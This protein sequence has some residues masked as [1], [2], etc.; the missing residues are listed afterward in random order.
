MRSI[1]TQGLTH[2]YSSTETV[3]NGIDLQ[4]EEGRIYGFLG[5]NGAGKT[6]TLRLILGLLKKQAGE[7]NIFGKRLES[8][9]IE[10]LRE[11]GSLIE[12]PSI[13]GHLTAA[14]NLRVFQT[15]YQSPASRTNEVLELVGLGETGKKK[16]GH[17]SLGMKQRLSIATALLHKPRLL[18]LDEP[19]NG[20]D[21]EGI[22]EMRDLLKRL[23]QEDGIT[24]LISSHLLSEIEKLV[25]DVGI[26]HKGRILFQGTL[27]EL[28]NRQRASS[29]V[30]FRT[31]DNAK[32][33]AA[34]AERQVNIV[35][36]NGRIA[37]SGL[38]EEAVALLNKELV[39]SGVDVYAIERI[40]DD[41]ERIFLDVIKS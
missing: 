28:Q 41:L 19:T 23:K 37:T 1:E 2:R 16:A 17:F 35:S 24:I 22:L 13:Y 25:D 7:I 32:A 31:S 30:A 36:Q 33:A 5:P 11:I 15:V 10:I 26:I 14:E 34:F 8:D 20:L 3:L 27:S 4:V 29:L 40:E 9:R 39:M 21:P 12:S 6:T 18:I 38:D